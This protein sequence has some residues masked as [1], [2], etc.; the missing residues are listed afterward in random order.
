MLQLF[1]KNNRINKRSTLWTKVDD[2]Y[3][4]EHE[5]NLKFF[6]CFETFW[7]EIMRVWSLAISEQKDPEEVLDILAEKLKSYVRKYN[8]WYAEYRAILCDR[9][10]S[11]KKEH[12]SLIPFLLQEWADVQKMEYDMM[13]E[14]KETAISFDFSHCHGVEKFIR[15]VEYKEK[16]NFL[17]KNGFQYNPTY[18]WYTNVVYLWNLFDAFKVLEG[19]AWIINEKILNE[20]VSLFPHWV[21]NTKVKREWEKKPS[22]FYYSVLEIELKNGEIIEVIN[23]GMTAFFLVKEYT[24]D[25][26]VFFRELYIKYMN[27]YKE[28]FNKK[29][30]SLLDLSTEKNKNNIACHVHFNYDIIWKVYSKKDKKLKNKKAFWKDFLQAFWEIKENKDYI[31][32][33]ILERT[34][35][36]LMFPSRWWWSYNYMV[37]TFGMWWSENISYWDIVSSNSNWFHYDLDFQAK[38]SVFIDSFIENIKKSSHNTNMYTI[39][40]K[41]TQMLESIFARTS[42]SQENLISPKKREVGNDKEFQISCLE[43]IWVDIFQILREDKVWE[44]KDEVKQVFKGI[45]HNLIWCLIEEQIKKRPKQEVLDFVLDV[46]EFCSE[47]WEYSESLK[48]LE[49]S[50]SLTKTC[51]KLKENKRLAHVFKK[52]QLDRVPIKLYK[53]LYGILHFEEP[54][55]FKEISEEIV[56]KD[57]LFKR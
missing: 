11:F 39:R 43:F 46:C 8:I 41:E 54:I 23:E 47:K 19:K 20:I 36:E 6:E 45:A 52:S 48:Y 22:T 33:E 2:F 28:N 31:K 24:K 5:K 9:P 17:H 1:W 29:V 4:K 56:K 7:V 10:L 14:D 38:W 16:Y 40:Q 30:I 3:T 27:Q 32:K 18:K 12:I 35:I 57:I 15:Y 44:F 37:E 13:F 55:K 53:F 26:Y 25:M 49:G 42:M 21:K 34:K 51:G 50:D